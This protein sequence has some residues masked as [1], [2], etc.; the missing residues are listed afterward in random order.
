MPINFLPVNVDTQIGSAGDDLLVT[1][2]T[3]GTVS[4]VSDLAGSTFQVNLP[5]NGQ[6]SVGAI[7]PGVYALNIFQDDNQFFTFLTILPNGSGQFTIDNSAFLVPRADIQSISNDIML[8]FLNNL[9]ADRIENAWKEAVVDDP[10]G[11]ASA[12]GIVIA[13]GAA[14]V[15]SGTVVLG[16][17]LVGAAVAGAGAVLGQINDKLI[18]DMKDDGSLLPEEADF[19]STLW[20]VRSLLGGFD[21]VLSAEDKI[22][23][24][25]G[26]METAESLK[27]LVSPGGDI[28]LKSGLSS[29]SVQVPRGFVYVQINSLPH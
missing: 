25:E 20:G 15:L 29:Q 7:A 19:L 22:E 11:T 9:T 2:Q 8:K 26:A 10:A 4:V 24:L 16:A 13:F 27:D 17:A 21:E 1:V 18:E 28:E 23:T 14:S 3:E 12:V 6:I 5:A